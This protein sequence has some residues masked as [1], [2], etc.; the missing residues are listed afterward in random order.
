[1]SRLPVTVRDAVTADAPAL[2]RLWQDLVVRTGGDQIGLDADERAAQAVERVTADPTLRILVAEHDGQVLG[3]AFV[4]IGLVSP[5]SADT[6]VHLSH[7]AVDP[8]FTRSGVG[9]ALLD[10]TLAWADLEGVGTLLTATTANDRESNRFFARLGLVQYAVLRGAAV[11][12][13]R[14]RLAQDPAAPARTPT[15][16]GRVG[17]VVAVRRSQRR[18]RLESPRA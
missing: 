2:R 6:A 9:R 7:C 18:A 10:A 3:A 11:A 15:R 16:P 13:L 12:A 14:A 1:M 5:L 17:Q 4:R 8:R